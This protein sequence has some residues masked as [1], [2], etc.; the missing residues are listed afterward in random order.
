MSKSARLVW[1]SSQVLTSLN[2]CR[3]LVFIPPADLHLDRLQTEDIFTFNVEFDQ[4]G[5]PELNGEATNPCHNISAYTNM[6]LKIFQVI[7]KTR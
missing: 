3:D 1:W 6:Y 7:M 4:A 2:V 5:N